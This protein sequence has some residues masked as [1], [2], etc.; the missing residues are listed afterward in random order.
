MKGDFIMKNKIVSLLGLSLLV[1]LAGCTENKESAKETTK[2]PPQTE[3]SHPSTEPVGPVT[4]TAKNTESTHE[5]TSES[6]LPDVEDPTELMDSTPEEL[7]ARIKTFAEADSYSMSYE[8]DGKKYRDVVAKDYVYFDN[9][10]KGY[11]ILPS[12]D[13]DTTRYEKIVYDFTVDDDGTVVQG[14]PTMYN[15]GYYKAYMDDLSSITTMKTF[16]N[17]RYASLLAASNFTDSL[18]YTNGALAV[19]LNT[20]AAYSL[21]SLLCSITGYS[22]LV[23]YEFHLF[24]DGSLKMNLLHYKVNENGGY[25]TDENGNK[26][27][28]TIATFTFS[29]AGTAKETAVEAR[30]ANGIGEKYV[31]KEFKLFQNRPVTFNATMKLVDKTGIEATTVT[32]KS[33][34]I[35]GENA[36]EY[37]SFDGNGE[38][39]SKTQYFNEDGIVTMK[40]LAPDNTVKS[41]KM[42]STSTK[43]DLLWADGKSSFS[44]LLSDPALIQDPTNSNCYMYLDGMNASSI[45][46]MFSTFMVNFDLYGDVTSLRFFK[47]AEGVI[48]NIKVVLSDGGMGNLKTQFHYEI[49][50]AM[51]Q[52][53]EVKVAEPLSADADT[54]TKFDAALAKLDGTHNVSM[55]YGS[56][57]SEAAE[58]SGSKE[59]VLSVEG[60]DKLDS[61][62]NFSLSGDKAT[63]LSG[64]KADGD[65]GFIPFKKIRTGTEVRATSANKTDVTFKGLLGFNVDSNVFVKNADGSYTISK[66]INY[67]YLDNYLPMKYLYNSG[68]TLKFFLNDTGDAIE[69]VTYTNSS[70]YFGDS[71]AQ[72]TF[73][74]GNDVTV[75]ADFADSINNLTAFVTPTSWKDYFKW[76]LG[77]TTSGDYYADMV[78]YFRF[79][80]DK[81]YS[82]KEEDA[83]RTQQEAE[84]LVDKLPF[85]WY[86]YFETSGAYLSTENYNSFAFTKDGVEGTAKRFTL[87]FN[88]SGTTDAKAEF[89]K[90]YIEELNKKGFV[91]LSDA[92]QKPT[93]RA[94]TTKKDSM[95]VQYFNEESNLLI[96][97]VPNF[98]KNNNY[99]YM[100]DLSDSHLTFTA[101]A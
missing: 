11:V 9:M 58:Y 7:I 24:S 27:I 28:E 38:L 13:V 5:T 40:Y 2:V 96:E 22:Q 20:S 90:K 53:G 55:T 16:A 97:L 84:A 26:I 18:E 89:Y 36:E 54:K 67:D 59:Y 8:I 52:N 81:F 1:A 33:K 93:Y 35:I 94:K 79:A 69:K 98:E 41:Q 80:G 14:M 86:S 32:G 62:L 39:T 64:Y 83:V 29:E 76:A 88:V 49:D 12:F 46:D 30:F 68:N 57:R 70:S 73:K 95:Y 60:E 37:D 99:I 19:N 21:M 63:D 31:P 74:Y 3:T 43:K 77:L 6:T 51:E 50:I 87:Y 66:N 48:D 100:T 75:D 82:G 10:K 34:V 78:K 25:A 44:F 45:V 72:W 101:K 15:G 23:N 4:E 91:L 71:Y 56:K 17:S 42:I 85:V 65:K 47:N 61:Y 92:E